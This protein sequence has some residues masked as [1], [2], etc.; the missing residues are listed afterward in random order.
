MTRVLDLL[1]VTKVTLWITSLRRTSE[2]AGTVD[3]YRMEKQNKILK[4][5]K[6]VIIF[7]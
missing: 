6:E 2:L 4:E 7:L 1:L 3:T 5:M